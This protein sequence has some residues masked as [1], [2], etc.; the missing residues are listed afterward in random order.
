MSELL[1][2]VPAVKTAFGFVR[3]VEEIL[4]IESTGTVLDAIVKAIQMIRSTYEKDTVIV[5]ETI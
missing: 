4:A 1:L 5:V 2:P 3:I